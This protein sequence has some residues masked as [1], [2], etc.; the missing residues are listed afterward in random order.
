[1]HR[2]SVLRGAG[3]IAAIALTAQGAQAQVVGTFDAFGTAFLKAPGVG[4]PVTITFS[5]PLTVMPPLN[6]IFGLIP[7]GTTGTMQNIVGTGAFN[8]P[9]FFQIGGYTFSLTNV[10]PGS[11]S[12]AL[13]SATAAAGQTCSP[14]GTPFNL[15]NL[16]SGQGGLNSSLGFSVNG[17]V[18]DPS[19]HT[20]DYSATFTSEFI[21]TYQQ[22]YNAMESGAPLPASYSVNLQATQSVVTTPE[23]SSLAMLGTGLFGLVGFIRVRRRAA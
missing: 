5:S 4:Q 17:I 15:S 9:N 2:M 16:P 19:S 21:Q 1:M 18:T 12:S 7:P 11:F 23:P 20:Y 10:V 22:V 13:C 14:P 6:G 8:V 3:L